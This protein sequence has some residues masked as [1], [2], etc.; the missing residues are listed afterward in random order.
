M[1]T[2]GSPTA[3][4][5]LF[6]DLA[7]R[8]PLWLSLLTVAVGSTLGS[9]RAIQ[10]G[11]LDFIGVYFLAV[12]MGFGGGMIR[13]VLLG[14][15]PPNPLRLPHYLIVCFVCSTLMLIA[16]GVFPRSLEQSVLVL[17]SLFL[18]LLAIIAVQAAFDK[19]LGIWAALFVSLMASVGGAVLADVFLN[20]IPALIVPGPGVVIAALS[21]SL[22]FVIAA[23][24]LGI[25]DGVA[26]VLAIVVAFAFRYLLLK[27][28]FHT[29]A[30][31]YGHRRRTRPTGPELAPE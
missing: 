7:E 28:G 2:I 17:D 9:L 12:V 10:S 24:I 29:K 1:L 27:L 22:T 25:D 18:G 11:K 15:L 5:T 4:V 20:Q 31:N 13:D 14:V 26:S 21:S 6:P 3:A 8:T 19:G 16:R 30:I 23:E